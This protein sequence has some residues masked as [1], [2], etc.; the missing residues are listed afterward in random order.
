MKVETKEQ[1]KLTHG[2]YLSIVNALD[3]LCDMAKDS[4]INATVNS[5]LPCGFFVED[6]RDSL[7]YII[8]IVEVE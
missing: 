3:T 1:V 7:Q 6:I 2:E 5:Q 8:D 4:Y